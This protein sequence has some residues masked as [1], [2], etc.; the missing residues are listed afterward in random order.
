LPQNAVPT[1]D[2]GDGWTWVSSNPTPFSGA[3]AHQSNLSPTSHQHVF[4]FAWATLPVNTGDVLVA[5]VYLDR[6]NP[7]SEVMLQWNNGSWEHRA[8]WGASINTY[9][10][11][12]TVSRRSMGP[13]PLLD[14][15]VRLE[16]PA[17]LVDLEGSTL[18]G[19]A[20]TL[21]GGQATWDYVGKRSSPKAT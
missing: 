16:V 13:L 14:Q 17:S 4:N 11:E 2:G 3:T 18:K 9:G 20:F 15:W 8:Y 5:Y 12:G 1:A 19:M 6:V 21:Y 10:V 7:P